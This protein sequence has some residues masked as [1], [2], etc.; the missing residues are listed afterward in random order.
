[1]HGLNS[2][3]SD[4]VNGLRLLVQSV[5]VTRQFLCDNVVAEEEE[6]EEEEVFYRPLLITGCGYHGKVQETEIERI[7]SFFRNTDLCI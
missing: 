4:E 2:I 7:L 6:E 3:H 1:M 5:V